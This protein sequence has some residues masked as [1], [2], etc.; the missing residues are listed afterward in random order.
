MLK[1][2]KTNQNYQVNHLAEEMRRKEEIQLLEGPILSPRVGSVDSA[3]NNGFE[4]FLFEMPGGMCALVITYK[5]N[6]LQI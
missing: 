4:A 1:I 2:H 5:T 6:T 3:G